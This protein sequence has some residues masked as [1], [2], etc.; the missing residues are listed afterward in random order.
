MLTCQ[1][2]LR[3]KDYQLVARP[4]EC[5]QDVIAEASRSRLEEVVSVKE[6][7]EEMDRKNIL[8]WWRKVMGY[9]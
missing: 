5:Q 2:D 8:H 7:A 6:F 9:L 4:G 3:Y 1:E